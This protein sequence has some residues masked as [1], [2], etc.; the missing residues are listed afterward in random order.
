[1]TVAPWPSIPWPLLLEGFNYASA[2]SWFVAYVVLM[3][4]VS[5]E[6]SILGISLQCLTALVVAEINSL[7]VTITLALHQGLELGA[8]VLLC[9][10]VTTLTSIAALYATS[11]KMSNTYEE[12]CDNFGKFMCPVKTGI[13]RIDRRIHWLSL[14]IICGLL[15][16]PMAFVR[17]RGD[18]IPIAL[19]CWECFDDLLLALA[20]LPQ[21]AMFYQKRPRKVSRPLGLFVVFLLGARLSTLFYWLITPLATGI[22]PPGRG[23]HISTELLNI[24]ILIDFLYYFAKS[25]SMGYPSIVLPV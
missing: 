22:N 11:S 17:R 7:L 13:R 16:L 14:Y 6:K 4:Q 20:L 15:S 25:I 10:W 12:E 1:M 9:G 8:D 21:L 3:R 18:V 2:L 24:A 23:V 5:K 19:G